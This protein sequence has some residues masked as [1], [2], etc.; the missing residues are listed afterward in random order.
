MLPK[1][2]QTVLSEGRGRKF[3]YFLKSYFFLLGGRNPLHGFVTETITR[4][5]TNVLNKVFLTNFET[6]VNVAPSESLFIK[7][8]KFRSLYVQHDVSRKEKKLVHL[9]C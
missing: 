8:N 1:R 4:I 9:H 6:Q 7:I 2:S 5:I 3:Q